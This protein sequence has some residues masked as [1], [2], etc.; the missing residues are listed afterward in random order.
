[1]VRGK[2]QAKIMRKCLEERMI[3][4]EELYIQI[5]NDM[6][7]GASK[8]NGNMF[9]EMRVSNRRAIYF[10]TELKVKET[11]KN[12]WKVF[13]EMRVRKRRTINSDTE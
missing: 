11:S 7:K 2:E 4:R 1:M 9:R 13:R 3:R 8:N 10:D 12:N 5:Q 6:R